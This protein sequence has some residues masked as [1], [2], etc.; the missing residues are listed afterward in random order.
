MDTAFVMELEGALTRLD[1]SFALGEIDRE[2]WVD[3]HDSL[4]A[5]L[6]AR[7]A[8]VEQELKHNPAND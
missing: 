7:G 2:E 5:W 8:S 1:L 3:R 6:E 4:V